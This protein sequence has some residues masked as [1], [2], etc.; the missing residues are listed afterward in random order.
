MLRKRK[1]F[2]LDIDL[3]YHVSI[4]IALSIL[5]TT[6]P[7]DAFGDNTV[8]N[9]E[10][11]FRY[12][13]D[14]RREVGLET[15]DSVSDLLAIK[16]A[17]TLGRL[18]R[19]E[20]TPTGFVQHLRQVESGKE[21]FYTQRKLSTQEVEA[22][23]LPYRIRYELTSKPEWMG[24]LAQHFNPVTATAKSAD[25]AAIAVCAWIASRI[26]LLEPSLSYPLPRRG[27]LDPL[28]VL[29][30]GFGTEV[31]CAIFGVAALRA[32]GVASRFVWV[33]A[34]RAESG[35]KAWLEYLTDTGNWVAWVPSFRFAIDHM[36]EIRNQ[37][38]SKIV[39]VMACPEA[40]IEI[41]R[42]YVKTVEIIIHS[43]DENLVVQLMTAGSGRLLPARGQELTKNERNAVIGRGSVVIAASFGMRSF[44]I[45]PVKCEP[46]QEQIH[47]K[48]ETGGLSIVTNEKFNETSD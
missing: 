1:I 25:E 34:L 40:P 16:L 20:L 48:A 46:N 41:T 39:F 30:G 2:G 13:D 17:L 14:V 15:Y 43:L 10:I 38:G 7:V 31:D 47:I 6:S 32:S 5:I 42:S 18:D 12:L 44:A 24:I 22:Y 3:C 28:T 8:G 35:G 4:K 26:K 9:R 36:E 33:P 37:I 19:N 11:A 29:K 27:D 23:I 21:R 45:M